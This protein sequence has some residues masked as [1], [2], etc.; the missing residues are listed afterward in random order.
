MKIGDTQPPP[1]KKK[2]SEHNSHLLIEAG[3]EQILD[4][5]AFQR[6]QVC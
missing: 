2:T 5:A 6:L 1:A 3:C 4:E